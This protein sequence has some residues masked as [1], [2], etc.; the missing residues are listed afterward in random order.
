[1]ASLLGRKLEQQLDELNI[2][3]LVAGRTATLAPMNAK[4]VVSDYFTTKLYEFDD[5]TLIGDLNKYRQYFD[6][7]RLKYGIF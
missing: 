2:T 4:S 7:S 6:D 3:M 5:S 1:M